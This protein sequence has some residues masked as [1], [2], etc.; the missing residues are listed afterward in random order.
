MT[1]QW[2]RAKNRSS[3]YLATFSNTPEGVSQ[4][5]KI[6]ALFRLLGCRVRRYGRGPRKAIYAYRAKDPKNWESKHPWTAWCNNH[7]RP[8]LEDCIRFDAYIYPVEECR[9]REKNL[10]SV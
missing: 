3:S 2:K 10:E 4:F 6:R 9:E 8:K 5:K 1:K 7:Y